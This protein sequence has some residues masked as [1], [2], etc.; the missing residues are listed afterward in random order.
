MTS[1]PKP[2]SVQAAAGPWSLYAVVVPSIVGLVLGPI[3]ALV[4]ALAS[5]LISA[6]VFYSMWILGYVLVLVST[7]L[8]ALTGWVI[9][10]Y[11]PSA[12]ALTLPPVDRRR[13]IVA[14]VAIVSSFGCIFL[15]YGIFIFTTNRQL[16]AGVMSELLSLS[17][18]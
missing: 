8:G 12:L 18:R 16:V 1:L 7:M 14:T 15:A 13:H 9:G 4:F 2:S 5:F 6:E 3:F 11:G 17:I 10:A